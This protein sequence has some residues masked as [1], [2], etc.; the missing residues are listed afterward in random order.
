MRQACHSVEFHAVSRYL[1]A[2]LFLELPHRRL[3]ESLANLDESRRGVPVA[4]CR[5]QGTAA[6]YD[7]ISPIDQTCNQHLRILIVY[8]LARAAYVA[9]PGISFW[10]PSNQR[11]SAMWAA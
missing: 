6:Q 1:Q 5:L 3:F 2:R 8:R 11:V 7:P 9:L 4:F 10:P